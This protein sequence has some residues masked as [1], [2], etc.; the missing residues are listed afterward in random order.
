M[1]EPERRL[2]V[3]ADQRLRHCE[4]W[5]FFRRLRNCAGQVQPDAS[6]VPDGSATDLYAGAVNLYEC[7]MNVI[8]PTCN[9]TATN[10]FINL[11]HV[12]GCS[13]IAR[14][15]PDQHA[16]D[17][18][19][20]NGT[21]LMFFANDGGIY[22]ALDAYSG[23]LTGGCG[24]SNQFDSLNATLGPMTQFV[25]ISESASDPNLIFGGTQDNGAPATAFSESS[26][27]WTNVNGGDDGFTA[28]SPSNQNEWFLAKPPDSLSGV[29]LFRCTNGTNCHSQDF[30]N[31]QIAD[32][33]ALGGDAGPFYLPFI[34]DPQSASSVL[35]GTCRIWRGPSTGGSFSLLSP[36]FET[37]GSGACIGNE[38]N[39]VR[40][41]AAG[42][43]TDANGL[44]QVIYVGTNGEGPLVPTIPRG[45][46][47]WVTTNAD[48]GP[49]TWADVT[50]SINPQGFPVSGIALDAADPLGKT[51]YVAIMGFHTPHLWKTT[52]AGISWTDFTAT[53]PDAPVNAIVVDSGSSLVNG[54]VYVGTDVG[55]FA[56]STGAPNWSEVGPT[57]GQQGFLPNVA[58]TSL[59]IFN[60]GGLKRLRAGTYG[61]GIW[62]WNLI[63]TPDFQL[64]VAN[65]P[66]TVFPGQTARFAGSI[67][68][69]NGY[70]AGVNLSCAAG[71]TSP[72]QTC[73][74]SPALLL[75][76][77][78]GTAFSVNAGDNA[79]DYVF[80][81]PAVGLDPLA[82][83]PDFA[84]TLHVI[85]FSLS[86]P[87]PAS[88]SVT[89][90]NTTLPIS[91]LVSALGAFN[92]TVTLSCS[93]LPAR[94]SCQ[95]QPS[96]SVVPVGGNPA[97]VTLNIST[98]VGTPVGTSTITISASTPGEPA[99]SQ[100]LTLIVG[101]APDYSLAI[102][103][104]TVFGSV[105]VPATF[106]GI[107]TS[108]NRYSSAVT[109]SCGANAS[110]SC[111]ANPASV[112]PTSDGTPFTVT[113]SS[114]VSQA[115]S[116][117]IVGVGSDPSA[118]THSAPVTFTALP[119]Q[120][121]DFT[122]ATIPPTGVS[123]PAG[124]AAGFSIDV[125][126][127]T[128]T[129]PNDVTFSCSKLPALTTCVF[130]PAQVRSGSGDSSFADDSNHCCNSQ[131][132]QRGSFDVHVR[133]SDCRHTVV[134]SDRDKEITHPQ[135]RGYF[136]VP[137]P[138]HVVRRRTARW[139]WEWQPRHTGWNLLHH[140][141]RSLRIS[142]PQHSHSAVTDGHSLRCVISSNF[143]IQILRNALR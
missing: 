95:F 65:S 50:Q 90:G 131:S 21:A 55:V 121:F 27:A 25:S 24:L 125:N 71:N 42:G 56:S 129:F 116:F 62:E 79:A 64:S 44:S 84:L 76:T 117:N 68:A 97:V 94:T 142:D 128:G 49:G 132:N 19:V 93:G 35:L 67:S 89:P 60:A 37:G 83:T 22:R 34:L 105:N 53:L 70:N 126:P 99:K 10:T 136:A 114:D 61:R 123:V 2:I 47:V 124:Q 12:Y 134:C 11:T 98:G 75:P 100:T 138:F 73:S 7:R 78:A 140:S 33:N 120:S 28:V 31:D 30:Q 135:R 101:A 45:G 6:A 36:D 46:H 18:L 139:R 66:V 63:T 74:I 81:V 5:R 17:F 143:T 112:I 13:D 9:G 127:T 39:L 59:K 111:V 15:H 38:T 41:L 137:G 80:N 86:A 92:A 87:S 3:D 102:A 40:S 119:S 52:N 108:A 91:F 96:S 43:V 48:A 58:V 107:L 20:A 32:S 72:P 113:V 26:G 54:M 69:L 8:F 109:L 77:P 82:V 23:L 106:N 118:I 104:S 1:A 29:N 115:Y 110:P 51:A 4:L 133:V 14:V 57:A 130:N 122:I 16:I 88:A 141:Y 85:D 103:N